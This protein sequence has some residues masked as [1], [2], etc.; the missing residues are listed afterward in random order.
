MILLV[1]VGDMSFAVIAYKNDYTHLI[2]F[3]H[4]CTYVCVNI[5]I[6]IYISSLC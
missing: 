5:Y 6:Y 1:T 4:V 3:Y 2:L